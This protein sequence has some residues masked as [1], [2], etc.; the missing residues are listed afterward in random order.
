M[1]LSS[2]LVERVWRDKVDAILKSGTRDHQGVCV[3]GWVGGGRDL[4]LR[5]ARVDEGAHHLR[6]AEGVDLPTGAIDVSAA[7][8]RRHAAAAEQRRGNRRAR[9][10]CK[11]WRRAKANDAETETKNWGHLKATTET[12]ARINNQ[13][14]GRRRSQI[15]YMKLHV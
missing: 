6:G 7:A 9:S 10:K 8:E 1:T 4:V 12:A 11:R 5:A 14:R 13:Q 15:T 3:G 2:D